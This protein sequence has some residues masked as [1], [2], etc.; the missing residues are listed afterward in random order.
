MPATQRCLLVVALLVAMVVARKDDYVV[1]GFRTTNA[2]GTP[3]PS[4]YPERELLKDKPNTAIAFSGGG[5]RSF[6]ASFGALAALTQLGLMEKVR[7]IAG[8]SGGSW[9]TLTY[10]WA[11][12]QDD[13][14]FL[15]GDIPAPQDLTRDNLKEMPEGCARHLAHAD[16]TGWTIAMLELGEA[17]TMGEAWSDSVSKA[18]LEPVGVHKG[19][20]FTWS[21][22]TEADIK[23][24]G[25]VRSNN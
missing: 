17:K 10:S 14:A 11:Q 25:R 2:D 20:L 9:A 16:I 4:D 18:Y 13:E 3:N 8:I 6:V 12:Q 23:V 19:D 21:E 24:R 7:Y 22:A 15:C 5:S 1:K